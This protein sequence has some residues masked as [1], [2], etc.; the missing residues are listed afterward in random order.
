MGG[1]PFFGLIYLLYSIC[2][3]ISPV[4]YFKGKI[5]IFSNVY[6][7]FWVELFVDRELGLCYDYST[8]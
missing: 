6:S 7:I 5:R 2:F 8:T 3:F 1:V 4:K